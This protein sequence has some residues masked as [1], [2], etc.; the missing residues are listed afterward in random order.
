M[1]HYFTGFFTATCLVSSL[2]LFM[3]AQN[4][5][6]NSK[7]IVIMSDKGTTTIGGGFIEIDSPSGKKIFD[8]RVNSFNH[9]ELG[10]YNK[11]GALNSKLSSS[12]E[13]D[14]FLKIHDQAGIKA[15]DIRGSNFGGFL[16]TYNS[17]N[18]QTAY[19]GTFRNL[20]GGLMTYNEKFDLTSFVGTS[21]KSDGKISLYNNLGNSVV[22]LGSLY[23]ESNSADGFV[24]LHDRYGEYG[25][26][27]SG[28][29]E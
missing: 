2:F 1:K 21:E 12:E 3:G 24:S 27:E 18:K 25:W 8:V 5:K 11:A 13:G 22:R 6:A 7:P 16:S 15:V 20:K 29:V 26:H 19:L 23:N 28:K 10:V 17:Q 14:G 9:G 4:T